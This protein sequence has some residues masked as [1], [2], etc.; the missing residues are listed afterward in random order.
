MFNNFFQW[1]FRDMVYMLLPPQLRKSKMIEWLIVLS[2]GLESI[3][4]DLLVFR[5]DAEYDLLFSQERIQ[6]EHYLNDKFDKTNR[7]IRIINSFFLERK[8]LYSYAE[9]RPN[10]I[11]RVSETNPIELYYLQEYDTSIH[12]II[13]IPSG[14]LNAQEL[15]ALRIWVDERKLPNKN[16]NI[17][18][19]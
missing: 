14:L 9:N 4:K 15:K 8:T 7:S 1:S 5:K 18:L 2:S 3:Q 12:F 19:V 13:E 17:N 11:Y 16:Y 10:I 6:F